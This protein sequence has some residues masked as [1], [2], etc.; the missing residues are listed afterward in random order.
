VQDAPVRHLHRQSQRE[1]SEYEYARRIFQG[2]AIFWTKH[3]PPADVL[4]MTRF[5]YWISRVLLALG[6]CRRWLPE[7]P[8]VLSEARL[9]AWRGI[10]LEWLHEN[11]RHTLGLAGVPGKIAL[12]Q[13]RLAVEW[14]LRRRFPLDDY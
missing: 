2:S 11:G 7:F 8:D 6:A 14:I 1:L 9:R 12:R 3:Y 10:C 13:R 4:R 5:Q